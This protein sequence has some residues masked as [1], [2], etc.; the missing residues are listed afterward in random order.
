MLQ[1]NAYEWNPAA[2]KPAYSRTFAAR[3][4]YRECGVVTDIQDRTVTVWKEGAEYRATVDG[5]EV[6]FMEAARI[7][8]IADR[9][10]VTAEVL[11]EVAA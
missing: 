3:I 7:L 10:T 4:V 9:V 6:D 11:A 2:V 5:K 8:D 1:D